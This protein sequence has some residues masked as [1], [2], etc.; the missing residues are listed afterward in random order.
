[1]TLERAWRLLPSEQVLWH[2]AAVRDVAR[3]LPWRVGPLLLA[4]LATIAGLFSA[5]LHAATLPGERQMA[6]VAF[7]LTAFA[8]A[9]WLAPHFLHDQCEYVL[10]ERRVLWRRGR[11]QRWIDRQGVSYARV[12]WNAST[13]GVG[14]LELVRAT[15]FGPLMRKQRLV[16]FNLQAPDR[17]LALVRGV[18]PMPQLGDP[19]L[20]L[21]DRL[22][23]GETVLW[24]GSPQGLLL[25]WRDALT[26][27]LG[28][29][30]LALGLRYGA[31]G[32]AVMVFLEKDGLR[33]GSITWLLLFLAT[34][35]S[36]SVISGVGG[37]LIWRGFISA[38]VLSRETEYVLTSERVLI[39]RGRIELSLDRRSIVDVAVVPVGLGCRNLF[40]ILDAPGSR[41]L[42]DS[43][44]L[45]PLGPA[46]DLVPPVL[47]ELRDAERVCAL[48][49]STTEALPQAA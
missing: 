26:G 27:G 41:A 16:L 13:P 34:A 5:L 48:L 18:T 14:H 32:L 37:W 40:L 25:G 39:R 45:L 31:R 22:D 42:S 2:G 10:T 43:G 7:Y 6:F 20:P 49:L 4:A 46:R 47:Y 12:I 15:P 8:T 3:A 1:M 21:T 19:D 35:L 44:A 9:L 23:D 38:R 30:V 24:G 33:V 36:W 17:V 28:A 29:L 11:F